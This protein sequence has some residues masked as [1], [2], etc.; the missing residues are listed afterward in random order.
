MFGKGKRTFENDF[1]YNIPSFS[2]SPLTLFSLASP[3]LQHQPTTP[4]TCSS[5]GDTDDLQHR[6]FSISDQIIDENHTTIVD[7][8]TS[9]KM[10]K[11]KFGWDNRSFMEEKIKENKDYAKFRNTDLSIFDEKYATLFRDSVAVGDQ[12]MTP[13]QFQNNRW[14]FWSVES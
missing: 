8:E 13:L 7:C 2:F 6:P 4:A 1:S 11:P 9:L 3:D 14:N 12:T 5:T 10:K